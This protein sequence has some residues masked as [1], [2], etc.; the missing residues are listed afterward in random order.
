MSLGKLKQLIQ[1]AGVL[2]TVTSTGFDLF[3]NHGLPWMGKKL[4]KW[5][6]IIQ[7]KQ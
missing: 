5:V 2:D 1:G 6:D 4:L 3:V 7:V